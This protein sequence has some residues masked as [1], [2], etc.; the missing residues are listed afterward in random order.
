M[1]V[2]TWGAQQVY[3]TGFTNTRAL[4]ENGAQTS[5]QQIP[6]GTYVD[7]GLKRYRWCQFN[8][9]VVRRGAVV[10]QSAETMSGVKASGGNALATY[11]SA[12]APYGGLGN[13][14]I[15]LYSAASF[16]SQLDKRFRGG[17]FTIVSGGG[18]GASYGIKDYEVGVASGANKIWLDTPLYESLTLSTQARLH[19]N[20][21]Y[22][23]I[24]LSL[25]T[26]SPAGL[27]GIA[28]FSATASGYGW[29]QTRG[30]GL[31]IG[32]HVTFTPG[33]L[34][35]TGEAAGNTNAGGGVV[36][37]QTGIIAASGNQGNFIPIGRAMSTSVN[38]GF[39]VL[40]ITIE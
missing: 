40:E 18:K 17:T 20:Q 15:K 6:L 7:H 35:F 19:Y 21:Y 4:L 14:V 13:A 31:A 2:S 10:F 12:R 24:A 28:T 33:E 16:M 26:S 29:L 9:A 34:V 11:T 22:G 1:A 36:P 32:S 25:T 30:V 3:S 37:G 38:H 23:L 5:D 8:A 27:R 39:V